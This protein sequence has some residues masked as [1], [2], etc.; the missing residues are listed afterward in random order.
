M[1]PCDVC[2]PFSLQSALSTLMEWNPSCGH[3][4]SVFNICKWMLQKAQQ[5][6]ELAQLMGN[7]LRPEAL[8]HPYQTTHPTHWA[9]EAGECSAQVQQKAREQAHGRLRLG[10]GLG[11]GQGS[12]HGVHARHFLC[13]VQL[14]HRACRGVRI[15]LGLG[16]TD[17]VAHR[18]GALPAPSHEAPDGLS[19]QNTAL[20][21][22]VIQQP[23]DVSR[24]H[25]LLDDG[26]VDVLLFDIHQGGLVFLQLAKHGDIPIA[27]STSCTDRHHASDFVEHNS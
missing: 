21:P 15:Q 26:G 23:F 27:A 22:H 11:G 8:G 17:D 9:Q 1:T 18:Q 6:L 7:R 4:M 2:L 13:T 19:R 16:H 3:R 20:L 10:H 25:S 24:L 5:N 14:L 12:Q